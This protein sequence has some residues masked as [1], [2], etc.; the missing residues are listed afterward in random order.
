MNNKLE[1]PG[2]SLTIKMGG[3]DWLFSG[4]YRPDVK[5]SSLNL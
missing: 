4:V 3:N 1:K 5:I 2:L